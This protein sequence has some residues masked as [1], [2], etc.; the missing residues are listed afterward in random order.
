M[1]YYPNGLSSSDH[2]VLFYNHFIF[3]SI[4]WFIAEAMARTK[5]VLTVSRELIIFSAAYYYSNAEQCEQLKSKHVMPCRLSLSFKGE[6]GMGT[7]LMPIHI[8]THAQHLYSNSLTSIITRS[9]YI[10]TVMYTGSWNSI[11]INLPITCALLTWCTK[12][13]Q[14][15]TL[16]SSLL[17]STHSSS[18]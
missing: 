7:R 3:V 5:H 18:N 2:S 6:P 9:I 1:H 12:T 11:Y 8:S 10:Y 16:K 15:C 13:I 14:K 4:S 17:M